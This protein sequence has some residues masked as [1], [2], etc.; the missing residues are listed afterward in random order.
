[1]LK[2]FQKP[3]PTSHYINDLHSHLLPG[4]DDGVKSFEESLRIL[5]KLH[6][7]GTRKIVTTP[8]IMSDLYPNNEDDVL[9]IGGSLKERIKKEN[10]EIEL[11]IAAEYF[12]DESLMDKLNNNPDVLLTFGKN[13][14]L[15]ETSFYNRPLYLN[16]FIF[17]AQSIGLKP[18]LAHPERYSYLHQKIEAIHDLI[19]RGV[20]LQLNIIS[21]AGFY[22]KP[23]K[24]FAE[25]LINEEVIQFIGS[26]CHN[27]IQCEAIK[28]AMKNKHYSKVA[29]S[30]LLNYKL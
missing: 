19:Q 15:F 16:E 9:K 7:M 2:I 30:P 3:S 1:M 6:N 22:S 13:Y 25:Q 21:L 5:R 8:H 20:L 17:K 26:D 11:S 28:A 10:I 27:E 18:V 24:K 29:G 12:L 23:I 14:L 4:I